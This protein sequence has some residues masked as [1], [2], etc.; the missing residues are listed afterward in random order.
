MT[1]GRR[2]AFGRYVVQIPGSVS[3]VPLDHMHAAIQARPALQRLVLAALLAWVAFEP[4]SKA[5]DAWV[6]ASR[7]RAHR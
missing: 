3:R 1:F 4:V 5:A 7:V 2:E 6:S